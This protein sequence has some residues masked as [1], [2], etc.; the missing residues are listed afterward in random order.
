M[1]RCCLSCNNSL[2]EPFQK[3]CFGGL[4]VAVVLGLCLPCL[5]PRSLPNIAAALPTLAGLFQ[6]DMISCL[7]RF[8]SFVP[9]SVQ[10][11][12]VKWPST[13]PLIPH[14][15]PN[16]SFDR[17]HC[18]YLMLLLSCSSHSW[19][20]LSPRIEHSCSRNV[21][22]AIAHFLLRMT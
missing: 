21:P 13:Y 3:I 6:K 15:S 1:L 18:S 17:D 5:P 8:L 2:L 20:G 16:Y 4:S 9:I 10:Y 11:L 19:N 14:T 12:L 22:R 7:C